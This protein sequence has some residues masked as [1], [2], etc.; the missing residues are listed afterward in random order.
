MAC[1]PRWRYRQWP[2]SYNLPP[3]SLR[4]APC[5]ATNAH[6]SRGHRLRRRPRVRAAGGTAPDP[7]RPS[8]TATAPPLHHHRTNTAPPPHHRRPITAPSPHH[9]RTIKPL[10]VRAFFFFQLMIL[11]LARLIPSVAAAAAENQQEEFSLHQGWVQRVLAISSSTTSIVFCLLAMYCFLAIDPRRLVFRHQLIF[12]LLFFDLVKACVLLLYPARVLSNFLAY[13]NAN[14]CHVVGFFTATS[15]EGADFAILTFAIHTYLLIFYPNLNVKVGNR[16]EGGLYSYRYYIYGT[17]FIIPLILASLAFANDQ[18][19]ESFV[20]WCYLPQRPVWLRMVLSWVPRFC[21]I[22]V[23]CACYS[24][25]YYHVIREFRI[26]G[27][28]FTKSK[29]TL[30]DQNP[31]F[32]SA[33]KYSYNAF[34]DQWFPL[35]SIPETS[36]PRPSVHSVRPHISHRHELVDEESTMGDMDNIDDDDDI[37]IDLS[38]VQPSY[39]PKELHID[40]RT[41][42]PV[43]EQGTQLQPMATYSKDPLHQDIHLENLKSFRKRQRIIKKQMKSIFVYP[44]AYMFMWLFPF[45]LYCTQ[46]NYEREHGPI[47]WINCLGAFMQPFYGFVD[48]MVFFYRENP[49][50]HTVMKRFESDNANRMNLLLSRPSHSLYESSISTERRGSQ[51]HHQSLSQDMG[52]DMTKYSWWRR[53]LNDLNMPLFQLPTEK[54]LSMLQT[55]YIN[56]AHKNSNASNN[57]NNNNNNIMMEKIDPNSHDFSNILQGNLIEDEFRSTLEN[58]SLDFSSPS[59]KDRKTATSS[60]SPLSNSSTRKLSNNSLQNQRKSSIISNKSFR[61][62]QYSVDPQQPVIIEG[63]HYDTQR[64]SHNSG[65]LTMKRSSASSS[66]RLSKEADE[67]D[68]MEF[69]KKGP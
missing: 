30:T 25:I 56:N 11:L 40:P 36:Q 50:Q 18:G 57:N 55:K 13:Y 19:Y 6:P 42:T 62:R 44:V 8:S 33:V 68:F 24:L 38:D 2:R 69:L 39:E 9:H 15:I 65:N 51:F 46:I 20:C 29:H 47:Y 3:S 7:T 67:M 32:F 22:L 52:V 31:S 35:L 45:I 5:R 17:S 21:I 27:G 23:I 58:F 61:G 4:L 34:R 53:L 49:W 26:L 10:I 16:T 41:P 28:V 66:Q 64:N 14:F 12:F 59:N 37:D 60:N 63:K 1:A 48:S 43:L 54:N